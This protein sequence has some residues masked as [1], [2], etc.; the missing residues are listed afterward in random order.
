[1]AKQ[2]NNTSV[3]NKFEKD[4]NDFVEAVKNENGFDGKNYGD[5]LENAKLTS[6]GKEIKKEW[7][8]FQT[9]LKSKELTEKYPPESASEN[10]AQILYASCFGI[11]REALKIRENNTTLTDLIDKD[12]YKLLNIIF[13]NAL[14]NVSEKRRGDGI[15]YGVNDKYTIPGGG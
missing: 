15:F 11:E 2:S 10:S 8:A 12:G 13:N 4:F 5:I 6:K 14:L 3:A 9:Y 1:M 7:K